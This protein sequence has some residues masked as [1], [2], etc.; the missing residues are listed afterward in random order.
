MPTLL[1]TRIVSNVLFSRLHVFFTY[2]EAIFS[3]AVFQLNSIQTWHSV[4]R[5]VML[6]RRVISTLV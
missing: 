4:E 6:Y 5:V 1:F 2:C 3:H